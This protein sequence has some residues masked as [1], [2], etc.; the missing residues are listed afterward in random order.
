MY[1]FFFDDSRQD[2]PS[3]AQMGNL[4][5]IGGI[6]IK[7][8]NVNQLEKELNKICES[9][10]FSRDEKFKWSPGRELWMRDNL[11]GQQ[12][13][14]FFCKIL[15]AIKNK[16]GVT[17][18]IIE[19]KQYSCATS[20]TC[21]E[22]DAIC[23]FLERVGIY[24]RKALTDGIVI[25]DRPGGDRRDEDK[26]L[27]NCLETIESDTNYIQH[28]CIALNVLSANSKY[29]RLLQAADLVTSCTLAFIAGESTHA[30]TVF[31]KIKP[32]FDSDLG[33][34]GGVGLKIHPDLKYANLYHWLLG[35]THYM[36]SNT[37]FRFPLSDRPYSESPN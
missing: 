33:R 27:T 12:R 37:G 28:D 7:N 21:H 2:N 34:I 13:E 15:E 20:A 10:G 6:G 19:D 5:A 26:F 31:E 3:R 35:D 25:S 18:V 11:I 16:S 36:R 1:F 24:L 4:V 9:V 22:E 8:E 30:P 14:D 29:I 32:L 17:I 23:L